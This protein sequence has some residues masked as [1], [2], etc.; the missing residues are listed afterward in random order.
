MATPSSSSPRS[1]A[2]RLLSLR[3]R[4]PI[5]AEGQPD[6]EC[7]AQAFMAL[8][9]DLPTVQFDK[10]AHTGEA[11]SVTRNRCDIAAAPVAFEHVWQVL[12]RYTEAVVLHAQHGRLGTID[13]LAID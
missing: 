5:L 1:I 4:C 13:H 2:T 6:G 3:H 9:A 8:D 12:E 10:L 11:E 7:A